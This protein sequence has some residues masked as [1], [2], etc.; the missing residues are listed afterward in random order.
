MRILF[1]VLL[2]FGS[3]ALAKDVNININNMVKDDEGIKIIATDSK[4]HMVI[5]YLPQNN[6]DFNSINQKLL[7]AKAKK[8]QITLDV[9]EGVLSIV[10]GVKEIKK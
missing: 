7:A 5:Y 2:F 3:V 6:E 1:S 9:T 4:N 8:T 10:D